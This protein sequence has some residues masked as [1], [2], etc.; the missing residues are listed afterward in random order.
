M[1]AKSAASLAGQA[2]FENLALLEESKTE[3]Y[4]GHLGRA[5]ELSRQAKE[6]A[7]REG[8]RASAADIGANAALLEAQLG[9][10]AGARQLAAANKLGGQAAA[11]LAL[12]GGAASSPK[13]ADGL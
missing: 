5:R 11:A 7:L 4:F 3:A 8:D 1:M 10:S 13:L 12:I 6:I 2:G 9:N